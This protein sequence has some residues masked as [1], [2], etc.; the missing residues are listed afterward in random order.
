M[1]DGSMVNTAELQKERRKAEQELSTPAD[2]TSPEVLY[3]KLLE[4]IRAYH[5][6][7]DLSAVEK[8]Y[9]LAKAIIDTY[10]LPTK[11]NEEIEEVNTNINAQLF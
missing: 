7:T 11:T 9:K 3:E 2:F 8:A 10:E 4:A 1:E 6:S 5:P